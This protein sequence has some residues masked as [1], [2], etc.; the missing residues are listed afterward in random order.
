MLEALG[1]GAVESGDIAD[2]VTAL[3]AG[4]DPLPEAAEPLH[5]LWV[6]GDV[7]AIG[8]IDNDSR[9]H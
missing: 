9:F 1:A 7:T 5:G 3:R 8:T 6:T 4:V 2:T